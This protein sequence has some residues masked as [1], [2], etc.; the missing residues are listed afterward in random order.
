MSYGTCPA[1]GQDIQFQDAVQ[2]GQNTVCPRCHELLA[3]VTLDPLILEMYQHAT[4]TEFSTGDKNEFGKKNDRKSKHRY[5][6]FDEYEDN[7]DDRHKPARKS[8]SRDV[9]EW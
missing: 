7:D 9:K 6:N 2:V 8:R 3:I 4:V 1:C 5:G